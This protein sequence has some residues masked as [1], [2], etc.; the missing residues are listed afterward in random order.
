MFALAVRDGCG[1]TYVLDSGVDRVADGQTLSATK[2][3]GMVL[4]ATLDSREY[5]EVI[6]NAYYTQGL[7]RNRREGHHDDLQG[8]LSRAS[9]T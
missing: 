3:S 5:D 6:R 9:D 7:A 2:K 4:H 1:T 8:K